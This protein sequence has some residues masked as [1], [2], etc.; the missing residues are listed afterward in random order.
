MQNKILFTCLA[1]VVQAGTLIAQSN[2]SSGSGAAGWA[3]LPEILEQIKDPE[4]A[5]RAFLITDYGAIEGGE[6]KCTRAIDAAFVDGANVVDERL[7]ILWI[8]ADDASRHIGPYG[9]TAIRTPNLD[10]LAAQGVTFDSAFV[11]AP[12]CSASRSAMITG[13]YQQSIGVHNH[14]SQTDSG[15]GMGSDPYQKSY[16]LPTR[17]IPE[18]FKEAGYHTALNSGVSPESR[19]GKTDYNFV[20]KHFE[21]D[22]NHWLDCPEDKPF[23]AQL[24]LKG[25]K[26]RGDNSGSVDPEKMVLPPYY[27]QDPVL[28]EDWAQYLNS[29]LKVDREVG[30]AVK[31]L[32]DAER[33]EDTVIFFMTDHG[34]SHLRGKQFLYDEGIRVPLIVRL[35]NGNLGGTRRDDFVSQIDVSAASLGLAGIDIPK[36][37]QGKNIMADDY[38]PRKVM[39]AARD[40][41]DETVEIGR[42]VSTP[43]FKYIRNFLSYL[44]HAQPNQYKDGKTIMKTMRGLHNA[45]KLNELQARVFNPTRPVQELYDL[46]KDPNETVNLAE[47]PKYQ[48]ALTSL[49]ERLYA[50]MERSRDLGL[51]PEPILEDLGKRYGSK[52]KVL[53]QPKN[54]TMVRDLIAIIEAGERNDIAALRMGLKDENSAVRYWAATW[55]G[56]QKNVEASKAL[57]QAT[58][59]SDPAVRVASALALA[60]LGKAEKGIDV[61][62]ETIEDDNWLAGMYAIRALE[63]SGVRTPDAQVA[64][65]RAVDSPYEF[66]RRIAR[67]LSSE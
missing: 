16:N 9:E 4:F 18:L 2:D 42:S 13:M 12:V 17:M 21:Y 62:L 54:K 6:V 23:F 5:D 63:W 49:R 1:L 32:K 11:T 67:R 27:P 22:S 50:H 45:G 55:L 7:N 35:P 8:F 26:N 34:I 39:F 37:I 10:T 25:G 59:D 58:K 57:I 56:V 30:E 66:T 36:Y 53:R 31:Q 15:K 61:I 46:K 33:L 48:K 60:R 64:V 52:Y 65:E 24:Q 3:R 38:Q 14:R 20:W 43:R 40:R 51:I 44:P 41:C 29:W 47:N 19:R 28:K